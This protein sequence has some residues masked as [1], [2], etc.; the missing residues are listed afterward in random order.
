MR[1]YSLVANCSGLNRK[2]TWNQSQ[3]FQTGIQGST[4]TWIHPSLSTDLKTGGAGARLKTHSRSTFT[5]PTVRTSCPVLMLAKNCEG[6]SQQGSP[7]SGCK[8]PGQTGLRVS[9]LGVKEK[10]DTVNLIYGTRS[11]KQVWPSKCH[12]RRGMN[13]SQVFWPLNP[14]NAHH[15]SPGDTCSCNLF[16]YLYN[17]LHRR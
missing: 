1:S 14:S 7:L 17:F 10:P 9:C 5:V 13:T 11:H 8:H 2:L 16:L 3:G 12:T 4:S 6:V 15:Q